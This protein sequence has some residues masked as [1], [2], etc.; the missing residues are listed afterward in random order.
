MPLIFLLFIVLPFI[1]LALLLRIGSEIGALNTI[2]L[3]V[4]TGLIGGYLARREGLS[5]WSRFQSR[6]AAGQMPG[7]EILDGV[8]VLASGALL[9]TPG[10]ITD[11]VGL[12]GLFPPT[13][14]LLKRELR[15]RVNV[16]TAT[17]VGQPFRPS[18]PATDREGRVDITQ[19]VEKRRA[20]ES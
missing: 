20:S 1:E 7:D 4:A 8:I 16:R 13:R 3:V 14:M 10:V 12:L 9:V 2:G 6:L 11:V 15:K 18:A 19:I 5:V 17:H